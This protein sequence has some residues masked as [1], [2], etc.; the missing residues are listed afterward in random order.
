MKVYQPEAYEDLVETG[1]QKTLPR[2]P[3]TLPRR[4]Q[5]ISQ[6]A[7]SLPSRSLRELRRGP[8]AS[9]A[10]SRNVRRREKD[11]QQAR[12]AKYWVD[13]ARDEAVYAKEQDALRKQKRDNSDEKFSQMLEQ[14][15]AEAALVG[16]VSSYLKLK[17]SNQRRKKERL[18]RQ[19]KTEVF[20]PMQ[21][22]IGR[23]LRAEP[24]SAIE[25]KNQAA[26]S[27][28]IHEVNTKAGVFRDIIIETEYNP[29][30][31]REQSLKYS[32]RDIEAQDPLK[33]DLTQQAKEKALMAHIHGKGDST[34]DGRD[35]RVMLDLLLWDKLDSTPYAR[36]N[37]PPVQ[38]VIPKGVQSSHTT[39]VKLDHYKI[40]KDANLTKSEY[41][42]AGKYIPPRGVPRELPYGLD[43]PKGSS[44]WK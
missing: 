32:M 8:P 20:T 9:A 34:G 27:E 44:Q 33:K 3:K 7:G 16:E 26:L 24:A 21:S 19:W 38:K 1:F 5:R 43:F 6:S 14:M 30:A 36:Y 22:R 28:Y 40:L 17:D 12:N 35:H 18:H 23:T 31:R 11:A 15:D 29:L 25:A 37:K 42:P 10:S 39:N 2:I 41:F 13:A 4:N